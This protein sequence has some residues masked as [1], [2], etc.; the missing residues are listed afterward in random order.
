[1]LPDQPVAVFHEWILSAGVA[2]RAGS[3]GVQ[4]QRRVAMAEQMR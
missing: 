4:G 2:S 1:M 3:S